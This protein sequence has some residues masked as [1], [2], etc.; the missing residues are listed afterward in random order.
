MALTVK[1]IATLMK[2]EGTSYRKQQIVHWTRADRL[3]E[4]MRL[5]RRE[6]IVA[7]GTSV[8]EAGDED[9]N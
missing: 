8:A 3:R 7:G 4:L 1:E 9:L 2:E 6:T 5:K